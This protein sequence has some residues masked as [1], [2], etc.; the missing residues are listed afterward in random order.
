MAYIEEN[1]KHR[2]SREQ[3]SADTNT[4]T[5][6]A[7]TTAAG[8]DASAGASVRPNKGNAQDDVFDKLDPR[9]KVERKLEGEGS[10]TNSLAM[11]TAIPEVDLGME[12]VPSLPRRP[13][14]LEHRVV[15]ANDHTPLSQHASAKHR[16]DGKG[17]AHTLARP[18][19]RQQ[20]PRR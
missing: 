6:V 14:L 4:D 7:G 20:S 8:A 19:A 3:Q 17:Q 9:Y 16:R 18:H 1:M 12:C 13:F 2:R 11:L 5:N 10:V 15:C